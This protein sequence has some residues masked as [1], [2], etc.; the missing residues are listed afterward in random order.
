MMTDMFAT[1]LY[2]CRGKDEE[3]KRNKISKKKKI[4]LNEQQNNENMTE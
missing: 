4:L 1:D 2:I 3:T